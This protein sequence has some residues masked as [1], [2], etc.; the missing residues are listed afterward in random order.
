[1]DNRH[2]GYRKNS[3]EK[4]QHATLHGAA[5]FHS[6]VIFRLELVFV[7]PAPFWKTA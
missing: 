4:H 7:D 2:L 1:M 5:P 3:K 6:G